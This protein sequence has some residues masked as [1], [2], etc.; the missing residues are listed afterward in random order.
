MTSISLSARTFYLSNAGSDSNTGTDQQHAWKTIGK[1]YTVSFTSGDQVLFRRG[2]VWREFLNVPVSNLSFGAYGTGARPVISGADLIT[3]GWASAGN[4]VWSTSLAVNP[5]QVWFNGALGTKMSSVQAVT[6]LNEWT[7]SGGKLYVY[8]TASPASA[9]IEASQRDFAMALDFVGNISFQSMRFSKG[10]LITAFAGSNSS[11]TQTFQDV[12]WDGSPAEGLMIL[13]GGVQINSSIGENNLYGLGVYG[14]TGLALSGSIL[15][16]NAD[17][18]LMIADTAGPSTVTSST[19]SGNGTLNDTA[20]IVANWSDQDLTVSNSILLPN[21]YIPAEFSYLGV[22]DDGTNVEKSPVFTKRAT[23]LIVVPYIDDY[24]NMAV[25]QQVANL[26]AG[27]GFRLTWALNTALVTPQDWSTIAAM[28]ANGIEIAAHTRTHSDMA[29]LNVLTIRYTGSARTATLSINTTSRRLQT[30]LNG[31]STPNINMSIPAYYPAGWLCND[32]NDVSGYSCTMSETQT[33][34]NPLNLVDINK[35]NI[36]TAYVTKA[37]PNKYYSYEIQGA[38][39]D[40]ESH[41]PGYTVRTFATPYSSY[42]Q[43]ALNLIQAGGFELNRNV[44]NDTPQPTRSFLL[45]HLNLM[46]LAALTSTTFDNTNIPRSVDALVESLGASGG[47]FAFYMHSFDEFS[48]A[49]WNTFFSE[50]KAIG[51]TCMTASEAVDY[52]KAHG[53]LAADGSGQNWNSSIVPAANYAPTN[54]SPVQG[55]HLQ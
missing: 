25:A 50:L 27:Y 8:G 46:E 4:N 39:A 15:S 17:S 43:T 3:T 40:I 14:G 53:T 30:F 7:Y 6:G 51:A 5:A 52:I 35:V 19:I 33:Y 32:I 9:Q 55:A 13:N 29:D 49:E 47:V 20:L 18:A 23:P 54:D 38:K 11:G 37:D 28:Q 24:S 10:N 48:L 34:F 16:G 44:L 31:S 41:I 22:T 36:K 12:V 21:P 45:S 2:D 42:N 26:A 1:L